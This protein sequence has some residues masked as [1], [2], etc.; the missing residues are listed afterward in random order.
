MHGAAV[1]DDSLLVAMSRDSLER[2]WAP[3]AAGAV[4]LHEASLA[5]QLDWWVGVLLRSFL[6]RLARAG[7]VCQRKR[8]ARCPDGL[9]QCDSGYPPPRSTGDRGRRW[10]WRAR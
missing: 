8:L 7:G 9:A 10:A 4:R 3:K 1:I 6:A 2:V 5:R